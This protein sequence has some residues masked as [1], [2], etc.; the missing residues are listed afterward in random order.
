M[1]IE[2]NKEIPQTNSITDFLRKIWEDSSYSNRKELF[3]KLKNSEPELMS[4]ENQNFKGEWPQNTALLNV[5]KRKLMDGELWNKKTNTFELRLEDAHEEFSSISHESQGKLQKLQLKINTW[6]NQVADVSSRLDK[7]EKLRDILWNVVDWWIFEWWLVGLWEWAAKAMFKLDTPLVAELKEAWIK[8]E[9]IK[10]INKYAKKWDKELDQSNNF[11]EWYSVGVRKQAKKDI[12]FML[13]SS[14]LTWKF[15]FALSWIKLPFNSFIEDMS[16][17]PDI[18]ALDQLMSW[19]NPTLENSIKEALNSMDYIIDTAE[20]NM[21]VNSNF[22]DDLIKNPENIKEEM[23]NYRVILKAQKDLLFQIL[24]QSGLEIDK[25]ERVI[26]KNSKDLKWASFW[27]ILWNELWIWE[28]SDRYD[29]FN[30]QIAILES[31]T[32]SNEVKLKAFEKILEISKE[33]MEKDHSVTIDWKLTKLSLRKPEWTEVELWKIWDGLNKENISNNEKNRYEEI[34]A[35]KESWEWKLKRKYYSRASRDYI[36][37]DIPDSEL[38]N[39]KYSS[40]TKMIT[41]CDK[42]NDIK[43]LPEEMRGR[44]SAV[45]QLSDL[46]VIYRSFVEKNTEISNIQDINIQDDSEKIKENLYQNSIYG[47]LSKYEDSEKFFKDFYLWNDSLE[48]KN[49]KQVIESCFE[50]NLSKESLNKLVKS[51]KFRSWILEEV[52]PNMDLASKMKYKTYNNDITLYGDS[53]RPVHHRVMVSYRML[54]ELYEILKGKKEKVVKKEVENS[55]TEN[56][57]ITTIENKDWSITTIENRNGTEITKTVK[58]NPVTGE[59]TITE[60][61]MSPYKVSWDAS[62]KGFT[63]NGEPIENLSNKEFEEYLKDKGINT[64]KEFIDLYSSLYSK[65]DNNPFKKRIIEYFDETSWSH[66]AWKGPSA[67]SVFDSVSW[68]RKTTYNNPVESKRPTI[69]YG[70]ALAIVWTGFLIVRER[71]LSVH[72]KEWLFGD[73]RYKP[74]KEIND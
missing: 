42:I 8:E 15:D 17:L 5:F 58:T 43:D 71:H 59:T 20:D 49:L 67:T 31:N 64:E 70:A 74:W 30:D 6:S 7:V 57:N 38:S 26:L 29:D 13:F 3:N 33:E 53:S 55:E 16:V 44:L 25:R 35:I 65:N 10:K 47:L 12:A 22:M 45:R 4:L 27:W 63:F 32:E 68:T 72:S 69:S 46:I 37:E 48:Y 9:Q 1:I 66:F 11:L 41:D 28:S 19:E 61:T 52:I 54:K 2:T 36:S 62:Q 39:K 21:S 24:L 56:S 34:T 50:N 51:N 23:K 14:I 18:N 73:Y 40:F 60:K